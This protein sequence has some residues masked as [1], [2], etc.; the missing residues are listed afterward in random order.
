MRAQFG[1]A[2][3]LCHLS[4]EKLSASLYKECLLAYEKVGFDSILSSKDFKVMALSRIM[5]PALRNSQIELAVRAAKKL[6]EIQPDNP[7]FMTLLVV[8]LIKAKQ[9]KEARRQVEKALT[10]WK[11]NSN[12]KAY[13]GYLLMVEGNM[14]EALPLIMQGIRNSEDIRKDPKFY[15]FAG[16]ALTRLG[17]KSEVGT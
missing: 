3:A 2:E 4:E 7:A 8:E 12:I 17:R 15:S 14:N 11:G 9:F 13:K 5:E 10:L 1:A 6:T 16:D